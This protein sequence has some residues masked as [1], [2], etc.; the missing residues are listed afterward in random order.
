MTGSTSTNVTVID[1]PICDTYLQ[2]G[3]TFN[4]PLG[5]THHHKLNKLHVAVQL[6]L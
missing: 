2:E 4:T 5:V 6:E 3:H 1:A